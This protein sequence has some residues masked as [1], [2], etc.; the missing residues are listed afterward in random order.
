MARLAR[1]LALLGALLV[2]NFALPRLLP[3]DPVEQLQGGGGQDAPLVLS[4]EA[5]AQLLRYYGLDRPLPVQ[6]GHYLL[7]TARGDLGFS[8]HF[9][10]PVRALVLHRIG[11]TLLLAGGSLLIAAAIGSLLGLL[12]AWHARS[13]WSTVLGLAALLGGRLPE[14]VVGLA[15]LVAFAVTWPLFPTSGAL[16][17]FRECTAGAIV[18]GCAGDAARHAA[19][20]GLTL[21]LAHLP[22]FLLITRAAVIAGNRPGRTSPS[23]GRR[24]SPSPH[25]ALRHVARNAATPVLAYLGVRVGL[26]LG[27]VVVVETLFAYP[28]LGQLTF[29]AIES[30]DYPLLE[31]LFL[32]FGVTIIVAG[33]ASDLV[34]RAARP[35]PGRRRH[36]D[37][38]RD[39]AARTPLSW[40]ITRSSA[41]GIARTYPARSPPLDRRRDARHR[42]RCRLSR[43][44]AGALRRARAEWATAGT[45]ERR[46]SPRH[47]RHRPGP[48]QPVAARWPRLAGRR[49]RARRSL[50]TAIA[51][52]LGLLS[53]PRAALERGVGGVADLFLALPFLPVTILVVAHLGPSYRS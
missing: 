31:A 7:A 48:L 29:I 2:I 33:L 24:A 17:P 21:I 10:Q 35:A 8:I 53:G 11:W 41:G 20:P 43:W 5:H 52:A 36:D 23:R 18:A 28:G 45:P 38:I 51:W 40:R 26:L 46:A 14:F 30:R 9:N 3:G 44:A 1:S 34:A 15:L 22:A 37:A 4:P 39:A 49:L 19:L 27:G 50:S 6:F 16:S 42:P 13:R 32:L 12:L 47:E 25:I